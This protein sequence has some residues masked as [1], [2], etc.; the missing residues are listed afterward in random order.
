MSFSCAASAFLKVS[1]DGSISDCMAR[2]HETFRKTV[3]SSFCGRSPTTIALALYHIETNALLLHVGLRVHHCIV[4]N[5]NYAGLIALNPLLLSMNNIEPNT[6]VRV[7]PVVD[8]RLATRVDVEPASVD[9]SEIVELNQ[10]HIMNTA[11]LHMCIARRDMRVPLKLRDGLTVNLKIGSIFPPPA[12]TAGGCSILAEGTELWVATRSRSQLVDGA[13]GSDQQQCPPQPAIVRALPVCGHGP[14]IMPCTFHLSSDAVGELHKC[15]GSNASTPLMLCTARMAS[16]YHWQSGLSASL[17]D[18]GK[19]AQLVHHNPDITVSDAVKFPQATTVVQSALEGTTARACT[20]DAIIVVLPEGLIS[21]CFRSNDSHVPSSDQ[22]IW[23][24]EYYCLVVQQ[25]SV[26]SAIGGEIRDCH[27][28]KNTNEESTQ[29]VFSDVFPT[30]SQIQVHFKR[31]W[32]QHDRNSHSQRNKQERLNEII[33]AAHIFASPSQRLSLRFDDDKSTQLAECSA[34]QLFEVHADVAQEI[35]LALRF[36][37]EAAQRQSSGF[38]PRI[39]VTGDSGSGR[40]SLVNACAHRSGR[41]V[42]FVKAFSGD[43]RRVTSRIWSVFAEAVM[44]APSCVIVDDI[45]AMLPAELEGQTTNVHE[46]RHGK[47]HLRNWLFYA[48]EHW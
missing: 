8:V 5:S 36:H 11:L 25:R 21:Q 10:T 37:P 30:P 6:V 41:R 26:K 27:E 28:D 14:N 12:P 4:S 31:L 15:L 44:S 32:T 13:E 35:C 22:L 16:C 23:D 34:D 1:S 3:T 45:D 17:L 7:E 24:D 29:V 33:N 39:L 38:S 19:L 47:K 2:V 42:F 20:T 48:N 46:T 43:P 18:L 40:S 9:D